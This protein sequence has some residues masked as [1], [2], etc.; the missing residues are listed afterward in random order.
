MHGASYVSDPNGRLEIQIRQAAHLGKYRHGSNTS[1]F[2]ICLQC[3]VLAGVVFQD[4]NRTFAAVNSRTISTGNWG[5]LKTVSPKS[6]TQSEKVSRWK[7]IWFSEV[8]MH[9]QEPSLGF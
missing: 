9:F 2:L 7:D 4:Q 8:S 6:L 3:G 5:Q 1:D